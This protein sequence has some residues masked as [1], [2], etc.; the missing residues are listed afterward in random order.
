MN[1]DDDIQIEIQML[2][3]S[4]KHIKMFDTLSYLLIINNR[5]FRIFNNKSRLSFRMAAQYVYIS[6]SLILRKLHDYVKFDWR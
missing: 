2:S 4:L 1:I 3:S 6:M 5:L